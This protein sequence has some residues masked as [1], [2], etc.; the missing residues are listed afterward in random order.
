[1]ADLSDVE[2]AIVTLVAGALFPSGGYAAGSYAASAAGCATKLYRGWPE[3]KNLNDDMLSGHAHVSVY[4]DS[5]MTRDVSRWPAVPVQVATVTPTLTA[6]L[7]G[8]SL[9]IGGTVT[10]GNVVGLEAGPPMHAYAYIAQAGDT[11]STVAAALAAKVSGASATGAV[12]TLPAKANMRA[13]YM[14]PQPV[15]T[16]TRQQIQG[17]RIS[18]WAPTP[19][20]RDAIVS[21]IDSSIS[22]MT[23][24]NGYS[25]KFF[26][27]TQYERARIQ[28][29]STYSTDMPARDRIWRR[30]LCYSVE[31]ATTLLEQDPIMLFGGGTETIG[32]T[33]T[34]RQF[35][36]IAPT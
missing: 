15:M 13:D 19:L 33:G 3:S 4:S 14:V 12:I 31:Y 23:N 27:V 25:T 7:A 1:M 29:R 5:G 6:T 34:T 21:L 8:V 2:S 17:F 28:Y 18:V 35:G 26:Q 30:D 9:T 22:A 16:L 36:D 20:L 10:A 24:A 32:I 11:L